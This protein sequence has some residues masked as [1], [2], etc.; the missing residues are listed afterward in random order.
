MNA[1]KNKLILKVVLAAV[2]LVLV[3]QGFVWTRFESIRVYDSES[4]F[5]PNH[6]IE[7]YWDDDLERE[8]QFSWSRRDISESF[9]MRA[10]SWEAIDREWSDRDQREVIFINSSREP[11]A[12]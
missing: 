11:C 4:D 1:E 8:V 9:M 5:N 3:V 10:A 7:T 6:E 12:A 2:A